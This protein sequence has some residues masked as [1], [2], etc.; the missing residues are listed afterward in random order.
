MFTLPD[1]DSDSKPDGYIALCRKYI[2]MVQTRT[3]I[4]TPH[5]LMGQ[6]SEFESVSESGN[7]TKPLHTNLLCSHLSSEEIG[8]FVL[9]NHRL[10][11]TRRELNLKVGNF[12]CTCKMAMS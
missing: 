5:F 3:R 9:E 8:K 10:G 6:E 11:F 4:P 7:V 2:H 1:S 12:I